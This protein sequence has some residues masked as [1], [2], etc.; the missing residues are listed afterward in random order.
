MGERLFLRLEGDTLH[1]PESSAPAGT[2]RSFA[3]SGL[4]WEHVSQILLY[5]ESLPEGVQVRERVIPDGLSRL[6]FNLGDPPSVVNEVGAPDFVLGAS[7]APALVRMR[8]RIE[9][10]SVALRPGAVPAL[11]GVPASDLAG[12]AAPLDELWG[13][14]AAE[15]LERLAS[16]RSDAERVSLLQMELR[17]R[18]CADQ[19]GSARAASRAAALIASSGGKRPLRDIAAEVGISERRMQ[20]L[21]RTY[22]GL[23]PRAWRRLA[24]MHD[25]LRS[26]RQVRSP[27][28]AD[29][30]V[31][32][33]YY[34]QAHLANEFRSLCGLTPTEFFRRT[35]SHSSKI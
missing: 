14:A 5:R 16:A 26:L 2:L 18:L 17:R 15:H 33:G 1:G 31:E 20:Q 30:A 22:V 34:D 32:Q 11:L 29:I 12:A 27:D 7:A 35:V 24:R 6:V 9:G 21:F 19:P 25:C 13:A 10:L 4:L 8:G 28:W 23:T 3:V